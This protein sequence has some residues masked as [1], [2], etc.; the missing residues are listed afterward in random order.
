VATAPTVTLALLA[1]AGAAA[2]TDGYDS[3]SAA[4]VDAGR[5]LAGQLGL[6]C[7]TAAAL[8]LAMTPVDRRLRALDL[9]PWSARRRAAAAIVAVAALAALVVASDAPSRLSEQWREFRSSESVL[10]SGDDRLL[11]ASAN[12]RVQSWE[13][14]VDSWRAEPL[15]GVGAGM[16]VHDW[17]ERRPVDFTEQ[18]AHSLYLE[19]MAELGLVGLLLLLVVLLVPLGAAL[20]RRRTE[21]TLW[22]AV[23]A[24]GVMWMIRAGID[25]DWEMPALTLPALALL[26][27]ACSRDVPRAPGRLA[28]A[29]LPRLLAGLAVLLV[30]L[31]PV[32]V[33]ASQRSVD[34]ALAAFRSGD[35]ATTID[36]ALDAQSVFGSRPDVYELIGFCDV[37]LGRADLAERMLSAAVRRDPRSWELRYGLALTRG[38]AGRDPR[39]SLREALER[40][41]RESIIRDAAKRMAGGKARVWR[42]EARASKLIIPAPSERASAEDAQSPQ[43]PSAP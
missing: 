37:R 21:R 26:A 33:A 10:G 22:S 9:A 17:A 32:R 25:W 41:P 2:L 12:G 7:A 16:F 8:R 20:R 3:S 14:A 13:V 23:I 28:R 40:N 38:A 35:C 15:K 30:A 36:R 43:S 4:T 18:D 42:R 5:E 39:P 34:Q 24:V 11:E 1:A 31:T 6:L 19:V 27:C 29:R